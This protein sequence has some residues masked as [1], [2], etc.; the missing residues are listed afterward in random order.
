MALNWNWQRLL[1][2]VVSAIVGWLSSIVVPAPGQG[3]RSPVVESRQ[4]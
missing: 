1:I 2:G 4:K 3:T